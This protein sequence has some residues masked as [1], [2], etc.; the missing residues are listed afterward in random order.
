MRHSRCDESQTAPSIA[1][2]QQTLALNDYSLSFYQRVTVSTLFLMLSDPSASSTH[3]HHESVPHLIVR[4]RWSSSSSSWSRSMPS[5]SSSSSSSSSDMKFMNC[6]CLPG[7]PAS[8]VLKGVETITPRPYSASEN[9]F[10]DWWIK[11]A[12][13]VSASIKLVLTCIDIIIIDILWCSKMKGHNFH[14]RLVLRPNLTNWP[15]YINLYQSAFSLFTAVQFYLF[16]CRSLCSS[17]A[18]T[19]FVFA[20]FLSIKHTWFSQTK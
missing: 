8:V 20:T 1:A 11:P 4:Y 6:E 12:N 14:L 13:D 18:K 2:S 16:S 7:T 10:L 3:P 17:P 15:I 19:G 5:S 9:A